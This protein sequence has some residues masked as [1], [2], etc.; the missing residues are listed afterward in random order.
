M[1]SGADEA[2]GS[3]GSRLTIRPRTS[4]DD[5]RALQIFN[6]LDPD[7]PPTTVEEYRFQLEATPEGVYQKRW[8]AERNGEIV[9]ASGLFEMWGAKRKG[10]YTLRIG[11]D[12]EHWGQG[13]GR[14]LYEHL[15]REAGEVGAER[16]YAWIR[17][18]HP[19]AEPFAARRG[20]TRTG[21]VGR[22]SRLEVSQAN[23]EG[24]EGLEERLQGEGLR[25]TTLAEMGTGDEEFLHDL[26]RM[27]WTS[28]QDVPSSEE[29]EPYPY[30][31]WLKEVLTAPGMSPERFW[32]ALDGK[33]PVGVAILRL[34]GQTVGDNDY[35][36]VDRE[37]RGRGVARALKLQT[38]KWAREHGVEAIITGNDVDNQRMLAI[39]VRLGYRPL[40][41]FAEVIKELSS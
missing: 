7:F 11:V 4:E 25:L 28:V 23:L 9:A 19:Y 1:T 18:S 20:F 39:N 29:W 6:S 21:R 34:H 35:T 16:L 27:V 17:E 24:Y 13:M 12:R 36:G 32:I 31:L 38:V 22:M 33:R 10:S 3:A 8:V 37:Y 41:G 15:A 5:V 14:Q 40:P 2:V 26:H 30:D